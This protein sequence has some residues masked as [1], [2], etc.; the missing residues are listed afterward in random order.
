MLK[1]LLCFALAMLLG[2]VCCLML[3]FLTWLG[4]KMDGDDK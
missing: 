3:M 1:G 4:D 2:F